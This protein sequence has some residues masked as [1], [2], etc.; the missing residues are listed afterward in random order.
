MSDKE[1]KAKAIEE[2]SLQFWATVAHH[3]PEARTGDFPPDAHFK[4]EAAMEGAVD[5]WLE[6]NLPK[7][8]S[9]EV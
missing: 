8:Q 2:A 9:D 4:I 5:T 1:R 3:Y 7:R 6:F